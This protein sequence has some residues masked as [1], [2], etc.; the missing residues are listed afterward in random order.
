LRVLGGPATAGSAPPAPSPDRFGHARKL[1]VLE[2][3]E[4][5]RKFRPDVYWYL[6]FRCNLA[7]T[8]CWV[9]SS[10][11]VDTSGDLSTEQALKAVEQ[12]AEL[13]TETAL[14]SGGEVLYRR[15]A[16]VILQALADHGVNIGLETNGLLFSPS[17]LDLARRLTSEE[18]MGMVVSLDGGTA[19]AHE[20]M[21]GPAT[22]NR[23]LRGLELLKDACIPFNVQCVLN[24]D[25]VRTI[26]NLFAVARRYLPQLQML[27]FAFLNP[28]GRGES[29]VDALGLRY[30][31]YRVIFELLARE[32]ENFDGYLL[33]KGP[34]ALIPPEYLSFV[35][36]SRKVVKSVSCKFPLL[37]ILPNGDVTICALSRKDQTL[38]FGNILSISLKQVWEQT[39]M[40]MLRSRYMAA[41]H[42]TGICGDC[43]F[44]SS[45]R[46]G[47]RAF[48]Y[49]GSESFDA[50][51]PICDRLARDG[52]LPDMYRIS[53]R[54]AQPG[55]A[56]A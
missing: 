27:Q 16:L 41:Q 7:C 30:R 35:H 44:K 5:E 21:R 26:P 53:W 55:M 56:R 51:H 42:L 43:T 2:T 52:D 3:R 24:R 6:S 10:P 38:N 33:V 49:E 12:I 36:Q 9:N 20:R 28:V 47:C 50:A 37:G 40:D 22:F 8:H 18:K 11:M 48:A 14:L 23:T 54:L 45:C 32:M 1:R 46:G 34:P 4:E 31:D 15:D 39:R 17:F 25:N 29:A 19:E 13:N